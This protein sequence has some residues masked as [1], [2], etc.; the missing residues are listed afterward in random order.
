[1]EYRKIMQFLV[2]LNGIAYWELG[3]GIF[4]QCGVERL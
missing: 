3:K 4:P 2:K 1:M